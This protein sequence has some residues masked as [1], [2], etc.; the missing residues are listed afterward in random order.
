[1]NWQ[2]TT[3]CLTKEERKAIAHADEVNRRRQR[4]KAARKARHNNRRK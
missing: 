1:M 3:P 2:I 4:N